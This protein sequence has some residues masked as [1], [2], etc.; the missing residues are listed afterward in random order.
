MQPIKL[1]E[2]LNIIKKDLQ[3]AHEDAMEIGEITFKTID[4]NPKDF[5]LRKI[6]ILKI[7]KHF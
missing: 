5:F 2:E 3:F 1:N 7:R 6:S 4:I